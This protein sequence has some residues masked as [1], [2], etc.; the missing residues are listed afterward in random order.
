MANLN[1]LDD[2][3]ISDPK[4]GDV[5]K[6]TA[7]GWANAADATGTPPGGNPC[8]SMDGVLYEDSA[9]T[10]TQPWVW[11]DAGCPSITV[12]ETTG[13]FAGDKTE[14]CASAFIVRDANGKEGRLKTRGTDGQI[15]LR[16]NGGELYFRDDVVRPVRLAELVAS[17]ATASF[18]PIVRDLKI[19]VAACNIDNSISNTID[20]KSFTIAYDSTFTS[21]FE[22]EGGRAY[23]AMTGVTETITM[24]SG[25]NGAVIFLQNKVEY[26]VPG[27]SGLAA[28]G[29][30]RALCSS[31]RLNV[32][33]A[34]FPNDPLLPGITKAG[35]G[36]AHKNVLYIPGNGEG[37]L[38]NYRNTTSVAKYDVISFSNNAS[39]S[40]T[41]RMDIP[42]GGRGQLTTGPGRLVIFPFYSDGSSVVAVSNDVDTFSYSVDA[43]LAAIYDEISPADTPA[44]EAVITGGEYRDLL[45]RIIVSLE[46]RKAYPPAGG[47]TEAEFNQQ[48]ANAW[49]IADN[50]TLQTLDEFEA[51]LEVYYTEVTK[52]KYG[53]SIL[54]EFEKEAG[55]VVR[56]LL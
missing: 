31:H 14:M 28:T 49:G 19:D 41:H 34:S 18:S 5:V 56:G 16:V 2:V 8:G 44:Q 26:S 13:T 30:N 21:S 43:D 11:K 4:V 10:I 29:S 55:N 3:T 33:N 39:V 54:F 51:A 38:L 36:V 42:R 22:S 48:I 37:Q 53:I 47:A 12:E 6:Y 23:G 15:E 20:E 27:A 46:S 40:F 17:T 32:A 7:Q 52:E 1:D 50:S 9:A 24:P 25:A 45:R 35:Y